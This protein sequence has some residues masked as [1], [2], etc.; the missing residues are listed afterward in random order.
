MSK[1]TWILIS[2]LVLS[3]TLGLGGSLAYLTDSD[4][5]VNTFTMGNVKIEVKEDFVDDS[6]LKPDL[7]I[8]KDA[9]I[10]NKGSNPAYVW[11]TVALPK[12]ADPAIKLIWA[13]GVTPTGPVEKYGTDDI[14]YNVYT[15]LVNEEL[16]PGATTGK[17]LDAVQMEANVDVKEDA[18]GT[19]T[20][21][22]VTGGD[23]VLVNYDLSKLEVIV[24]GYAIQDE[25]FDTAGEAYAAY[26]TQWDWEN[27]KIPTEE[28]DP[29][30]G[31]EG[32]GEPEEEPAVPEV[33]WTEVNTLKELR[34]AVE[35]G[36]NVKLMENITTWYSI[37][38]PQGKEVVLDLDKFTISR[39]G[40]GNGTLITNN[41][42]L[43]I[44]NGNVTQTGYILNWNDGKITIGGKLFNENGWYEFTKENDSLTL[45]KINR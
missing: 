42:T 24:T 21:W 26:N 2:C 7:E 22:L 14:L 45:E 38:V 28:S 19:S 33:T 11:M 30:S 15:V 20:Y 40:N 35:A 9:E 36:G 41:G 39:N 27:N 10:V 43:T 12:E 1:K 37:N 44:Q 4:T 17:L 13:N 32:N 8:N 18:E 34:T 23:E 16:A 25:G 31:D 6:E 5:R 3:L 29:A